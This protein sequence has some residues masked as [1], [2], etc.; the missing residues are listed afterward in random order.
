MT[1]HPNRR[2]S[3]DS[4]PAPDAIKAARAAAGLTQTQAAKLVHMEQ[5]GWARWESGDRRM[6]PAIWELWQ[7]KIGAS[8]QSPVSN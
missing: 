5:R 1:N 7:I 8:D 2:P 3:A 4:N 6:H